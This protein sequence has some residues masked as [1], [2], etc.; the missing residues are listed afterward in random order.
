MDDDVQ[1]LR[2][3]WAQRL[4]LC[5]TQHGLFRL[6]LSVCFVFIFIGCFIHAA[7]QS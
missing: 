1:I 2:E 7:L 5:V 3:A 6:L 4:D